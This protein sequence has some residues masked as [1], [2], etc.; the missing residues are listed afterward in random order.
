M[1]VLLDSSMNG[2]VLIIENQ[3]DYFENRRIDRF[4]RGWYWR[5][6]VGG[7]VVVGFS[8]FVSDALSMEMF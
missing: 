1:N 8:N 7:N 5:G 4:W 6:N 3:F 2:N